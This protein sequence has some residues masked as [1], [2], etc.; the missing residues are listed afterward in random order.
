MARKIHGPFCD[1][2]IQTIGSLGSTTNNNDV[3][4]NLMHSEMAM[5][6]HADEFSS[7][8]LTQF[9]D[10]IKKRAR[11]KANTKSSTHHT[12]NLD[13]YTDMYGPSGFNIY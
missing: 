11:T 8:Q 1:V 13:P 12:V 5:H 3:F 9:V 7:T 4:F 2:S 10:R 6:T